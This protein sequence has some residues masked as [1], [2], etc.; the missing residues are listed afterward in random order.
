MLHNFFLIISL[1]ISSTAFAD[2]KI[3]VR[4]N[5]GNVYDR[6]LKIM[7][8]REKGTKVEN[9]GICASACVMF[10]SLPTT[11]TTKDAWWG[12]HGSS[13]GPLAKTLADIQMVGYIP[14]HIID[15]LPGDWLSLSGKDLYWYRGDQLIKLGVPEC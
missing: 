5:G 14:Q 9:T 2:T 15:I 11:C 3:I 13:G 8:Y 1:F 7:E 6:V 4:D 12:F 10:L